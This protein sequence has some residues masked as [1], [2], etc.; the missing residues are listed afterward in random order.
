MRKPKVTTVGRLPRIILAS[1]CIVSLNSAVHAQASDGR[2][3]ACYV[4]ASGTVYRIREANTPGSCFSG[5]IEFSWLPPQI[6]VSSGDPPISIGNVGAGPGG[7]FHSAN[8][9]GVSGTSDAFD[10]FA[11]VTGTG[12]RNGVQGFAGAT[13]FGWGVKGVAHG[14]SVGVEGTS[15]SGS[16]IRGQALECNNSG[17][18]PTSGDAGQFVAGTGGILVHGFFARCN[19]PGCW[20]EKFKVGSDGSGFFGG[21]LTVAGDAQKPGG[22]SWSTLSDR[23]TK[24]AIV[25]I[26][27]ALEQLLRLRGVT[28]EYANPAL[29]RESPGRHLGMVA[30]DVEE[31]FP[32]WVDTGSDGYKRVTFRGFEALAVEA[33]RE[34]HAQAAAERLTTEA[35]ITEL[36]RQNAELR[37]MVEAL[38]RD[39]ESRKRQ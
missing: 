19:G 10:N 38:L 12:F 34:L 3:H 15:Q 1:L 22:G 7:I 29:V 11:G 31:V 6:E 37:R 24:T 2:I 32:S 9:N 39:A 26:E 13:D 18:T 35:R 4:P 8:N 5:H 17:C 20:D 14:T 33:V 21:N 28:F 25:P 23:R 16:G 27:N 36:E 30:Q